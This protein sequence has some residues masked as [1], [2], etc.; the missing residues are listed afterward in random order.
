MAGRAGRRGYDT[1]GN[2]VLLPTRFD[3]A[4]T[5][6]GI[7]G[8]GPEPLSS[9]FSTSYGMVLNLLSCYSLDQAREFLSKSFGQYM[10]GAGNA[11]RLREV[12]LRVCLCV[13]V[14]GEGLMGCCSLDQARGFL[15]KSFGQYMAE[16]GNAS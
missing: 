12:G 1:L 9:Q 6:A 5:G 13:A 14:C 4:E 11:R 7:I 3:G 15:V 16:S 10:S 8:A 2:C